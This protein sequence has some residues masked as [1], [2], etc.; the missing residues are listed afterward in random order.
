[1][2]VQPMRCVTLAL[3]LAVPLAATAH[4]GPHSAVDAA[5]PA[6]APSARP[7]VEVV[8]QFSAALQ[9]GDLQ[10]AGALL[11][12]D[13]LILESGGAE[14]SREEYLSGHATHD[15]AFL[16]GA[17]VQ[18][19][20][21]TANAVGDLAWVATEGELHASKKGKPLTLLSSETMVLKRTAQGWRIAHIHWSSRAKR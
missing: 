5:D 14:R 1:M 10:R 15:A 9:A 20:Q 8:T 3:L 12:D 21:R 4:N 11:T 16:K 17:H 18:V 13:V 6:T 19:K 7:A 2:N